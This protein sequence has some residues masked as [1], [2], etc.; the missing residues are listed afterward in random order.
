MVLR[1][2]ARSPAS[3]PDSQ[4]KVDLE[5]GQSLAELVVDLAGD[6]GPLLLAN[7]LQ[8]PGQRAELVM[9][10]P[11]PLLRP[12][13]LAA[14]FGLAEGADH[15]GPQAGEAVL[16]DIVRGSQLQ[17]LDHDF[18]AHTAG[19]EDEGHIGRVLLRDLQ[20]GG[21]VEIREDVVGEDDP[22]GPR[23]LGLEE[24]P[25]LDRDQREHE[26][27]VE[28]G[29]PD[30]LHVVLAVLDE[31]DAQR[32]RVRGVPW[33][34]ALSACLDC[35]LMTNGLITAPLVPSPP[36]CSFFTG[37]LRVARGAGCGARGARGS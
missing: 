22:R 21:T 17:H 24:L 27:G 13:V 1:C 10:A 12:L 36:L 3:R 32:L 20:G 5:P 29:V 9:G 4:E 14:L 18:L 31:D 26:P 6:P 8:V 35:R 2:S 7:E 19:D 25:V 37:L 15:G 16:Q 30:Q 28:E 11:Q 23:E 33:A 34:A